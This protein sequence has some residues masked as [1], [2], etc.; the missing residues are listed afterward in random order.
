M[1]FYDNLMGG[2]IQPQVKLV[3]RDDRLANLGSVLGDMA[4]G[5][6]SDALRRVAECEAMQVLWE[7]LDADLR[8]RCAPRKIYAARDGKSVVKTCEMLVEDGMTAAVLKRRKVKLIRD[9]AE[10][11]GR[12]EIENVS[13]VIAKGAELYELLVVLKG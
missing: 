5:L 10:K 11:L 4:S 7:M 1:T 12:V 13:F 9:V 3:R 8:R 2:L 6:P